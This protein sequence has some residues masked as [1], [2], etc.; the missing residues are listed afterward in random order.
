MTVHALEV[1]LDEMESIEAHIATAADSEDWDGVQTGNALM[2][3][4]L[5]Q[6]DSLLAVVPVGVTSDELTGIAHRLGEVLQGHNDVCFMLSELRE[7]TAAEQRSLKRG[8]HAAGRYLDVAG[9][10]GL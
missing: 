3:S 1:L 9:Q 8:H 7:M 10:L 4:C 5:G 2:N 6:L